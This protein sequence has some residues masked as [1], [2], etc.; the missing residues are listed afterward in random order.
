[1]NQK[2]WR[3][4]LR[5]Y[6]VKKSLKWWKS[7]EKKNCK[8][9]SQKTLKKNFLFYLFLKKRVR[10]DESVWRVCQKNPAKL[11]KIIALGSPEF[12]WFNL[13]KSSLFLKQFP[14]FFLE[15]KMNSARSS[16]INKSSPIKSCHPLDRTLDFL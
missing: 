1:L 13:V 15:S 16:K 12:L 4:E 5:N 8:Q 14:L 11:S 9:N 6:F 2:S 10:S 3:P 7:S